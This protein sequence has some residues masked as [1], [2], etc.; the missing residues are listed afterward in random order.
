MTMTAVE[1][2]VMIDDADVTP[3]IRLV[4]H[5]LHNGIEFL[6]DSGGCDECIA[7][8]EKAVVAALLIETP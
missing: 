6:R 5:S 8:L 4:A 1:R 7:K 3:Q 2:A